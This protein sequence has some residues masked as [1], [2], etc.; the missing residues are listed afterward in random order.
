MR[1]VELF[2]G[3]PGPG[4]AV[5]GGVLFL[6]GP[7]GIA[8]LLGQLANGLGPIQTYEHLADDAMGRYEPAALVHAGQG[9]RNR[10]LEARMTEAAASTRGSGGRP[11]RSRR[12][13]RAL[14]SQAEPA[15]EE[16]LAKR[17]SA[18]ATLWLQS[19][20]W[21]SAMHSVSPPR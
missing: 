20:A 18:F 8:M 1:D 17:P 7:A 9:H 4:Q 10:E 13:T 12:L 19:R 3:C 16:Q 14:S 15:Q 2:S 6:A 21:A 5:A 11:G